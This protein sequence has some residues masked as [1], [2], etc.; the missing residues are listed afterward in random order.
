M[1]NETK[2]MLV[3]VTNCDW[4]EIILIVLK[5]NNLE[6]INQL[7]KSLKFNKTNLTWFN[8]SKIKIFPFN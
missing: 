3:S 4:K 1:L 7:V 2:W 6:E 8:L 5:I